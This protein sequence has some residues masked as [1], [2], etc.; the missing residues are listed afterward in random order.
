MTPHQITLAEFFTNT[1]CLT[2]LAILI[3]YFTCAGILFGYI[4][5]RN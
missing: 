5:T 2:G 1:N 4:L 3:A